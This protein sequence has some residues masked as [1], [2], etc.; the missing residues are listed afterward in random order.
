MEKIPR[1]VVAIVA[2]A[3]VVAALP[4]RASA[5][6]DRGHRTVV[7][8]AARYLE[9]A[10]ACEVARLLETDTAHVA[11]RLADVAS[12]A[13]PPIKRERRYT[14]NWHFVDIPVSFDAKHEPTRHTYTACE[15]CVADDYGDCA[16]GALSRLA[17]V[18][19]N[20]HEQPIS[21]VEALKF[22][23][24]IVGDIHQPFHAINDETDGTKKGDMGGNLKAINWLGQTTNPRWK[25]Q[26][27]LH[28][29]WDEGIID[30]TFTRN[31]WSDADEAKYAAKL[32]GTLPA[33]GSAEWQAIERGTPIEWT[34]ASYGLGVEAYA[35]MWKA[36]YDPA[37]QFT[38]LDRKPHTGIFTFAVAE[39]TTDAPIVDRQLQRAGVRLAKLLNDTL[40][41]SAANCTTAA[42][43]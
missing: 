21:R 26:W 31:G 25:D 9:P 29:V 38:G 42:G 3:L 13:D 24:H 4:S 12:W 28:S 2:S 30:E 39:Y 7:R 10:V 18:L 33:P 14:S 19:G 40:R 32:V 36:P 35:R 1:F 27:T 8:I 17:P 15:H 11:D 16:L 34:T 23:V 5:W 6:G 20:V 43:K 37:Y 41:D 22:V